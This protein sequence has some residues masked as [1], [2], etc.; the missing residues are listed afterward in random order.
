LVSGWALIEARDEATLAEALAYA[1]QI[2][3]RCRLLGPALALASPQDAAELR[4][5]LARR[6]YDL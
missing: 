4:D 2:A 3:A 5:I 1:P 6:G